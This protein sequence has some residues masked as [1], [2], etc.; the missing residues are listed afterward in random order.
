MISQIELREMILEVTYP[1]ASA[2]PP[3]IK[4]IMVRKAFQRGQSLWLD[5]GLW[6]WD[7]RS[8][9]CCALAA[10][11]L[12]APRVRSLLESIVACISMSPPDDTKR[13]ERR[14]KPFSSCVVL[15]PKQRGPMAQ[16]AGL[17]QFDRSA[18]CTT[19][20][21]AYH[22]SSDGPSSSTHQR[23]SVVHV[24]LWPQKH[25][26]AAMMHIFLLPSREYG[27]GSGS[28]LSVFRRAHRPHHSRRHNVPSCATGVI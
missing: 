12:C 18:I 24:V 16:R 11:L 1:R 14:G 23:D 15:G 21:I 4:T 13:G 7:S 25:R 28:S 27:W 20:V 9:R 8:G 10:V 17:R 5:S 22:F 3:N 19:A 26:T 6:R 2:S